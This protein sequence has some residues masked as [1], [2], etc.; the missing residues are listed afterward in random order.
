M[1]T[2]VECSE[3][4]PSLSLSVKIRI[5]PNSGKPH[6]CGKPQKVAE[7][8][9]EEISGRSHASPPRLVPSK[10]PVPVLDQLLKL[11]GEGGEGRGGDGAGERVSLRRRM[12]P[13]R[14]WGRRRGG[15][16]PATAARKR[17]PSQS[18][19]PAQQLMAENDRNWPQQRHSDGPQDGLSGQVTASATDTGHGDQLGGEGDALCR[20]CIETYCLF[21]TY[22]EIQSHRLFKLCVCLWMMQ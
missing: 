7:L 14:M 2:G 13:G 1:R 10:H 9:S 18:S 17:R 12:P 3:N 11:G 19:E 20:C 22:P 21:I 16:L 4:R 15:G 6:S 5:T 8:A